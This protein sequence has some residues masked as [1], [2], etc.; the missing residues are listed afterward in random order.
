MNDVPQ[1]D[2]AQRLRR[3]FLWGVGAAALW[4]G[5][6]LLHPRGVLAA[7]GD[8]TAFDSRTLAEVL[9][10]IGATNVLD[11][12]SA[13]QIR[14]PDVAENG[15]VVAVDIISTLPNTR[16]ISLVVDHNPFPLTF[17]FA[18]APAVAPQI[19]T[20]IKM[21]ETSLLRVVADAGGKI[22]VAQREVK[23]T[24]GGCGS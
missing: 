2:R 19:G 13:L 9:S 23:V 22:Y 11:G 1:A 3:H 18:F 14:A 24:V 10:L 12:G 8:R 16:K 6:G 17:Q 7:P 4:V 20:R 5:T 15:A 21:N